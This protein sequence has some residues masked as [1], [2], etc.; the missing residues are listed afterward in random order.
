MTN[1]MENAV[2]TAIDEAAASIATEPV[3]LSSVK[4]PTTLTDQVQLIERY[5]REL[6]ARLRRE[7]IEAKCEAERRITDAHADYARQLSEETARLERERDETVR[8]AE[9]AY[10]AKLHELAALLRRRS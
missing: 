7:S 8:Q 9:D 3:R 1:D 10:H 4:R 6:D 5:E 2:A